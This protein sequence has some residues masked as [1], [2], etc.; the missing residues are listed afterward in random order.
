MPTK[1]ELQPYSDAVGSSLVKLTGKW[2]NEL[3]SVMTITSQTDD[4]LLSGLYLSKVSEG[5]K[6]VEG[7]LTG[8]V[9][10]DSVGFVVDWSPSYDSTASWS[11]KILAGPGKTPYIYTLWTLSKHLDDADWWDSFSSGSDHFTAIATE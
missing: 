1:A 4:G 3:G 9:A 6:E 7:K 2:V 10:G 8:Y 11:G 5:H